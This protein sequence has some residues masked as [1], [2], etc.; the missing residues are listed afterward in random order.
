MI[1][2]SEV[3]VKCRREIDLSSKHAEVAAGVKSEVIAAAVAAVA[4][5]AAAAV[6]A[7]DSASDANDALAAAVAVDE[8]A[9]GNDQ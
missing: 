3:K 4:V 9:I 1:H 6:A 8:A 5:A 7:S 2:Y